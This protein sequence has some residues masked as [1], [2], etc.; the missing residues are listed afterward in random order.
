[1]SSTAG[2][3]AQVAFTGTHID[4]ITAKGPAYGQANVFIDGVQQG[5]TIDLYDPTQQWQVPISF[6]GLSASSTHILQIQVLNTSNPSST[7]T[8]V[9][10]DAFHGLITTMPTP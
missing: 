7:G 3:V 8:A 5:G 4:W 2:A 10:V 1:M 9:P 6:T